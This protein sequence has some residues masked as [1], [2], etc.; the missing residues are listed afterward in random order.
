MKNLLCFLA[1]TLVV[2]SP[3]IATAQSDPKNLDVRAGVWKDGQAAPWD[4]NIIDHYRLFGFPE[5][6]RGYSPEQPIKFSHKLHAGDLK[7]ECQFCHWTVT[8]SPFAAI[9]EAE[10]CMGCHAALIPK[11][12]PEVDKLKKY[13]TDNQPIPWEKVHVMP[14]HVKFNHK[15]HVKAG[16]TCQECHGQVPQMEV[17]E[18]AS[19]MKMGWCIDCHRNRGAS[20]DCSTCHK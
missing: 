17:V 18:R 3:L 11:Q 4:L 1:F 9:P 15:R 8:K 5:R 10:I 19:S 14:D 13:Y 16:V 20:I 6:A 2:I 7:M 12:S